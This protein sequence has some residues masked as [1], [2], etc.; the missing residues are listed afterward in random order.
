MTWPAVCKWFNNQEPKVNSGRSVLS[1]L[2][3]GGKLLGPV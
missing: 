1:H 3:C 2:P